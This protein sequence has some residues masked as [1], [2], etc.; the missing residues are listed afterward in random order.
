MRLHRFLASGET[1]E[2]HET[3][4]KQR[5]LDETIE[6]LKRSRLYITYSFINI[7]ITGPLLLLFSNECLLWYVVFTFL[8]PLLSLSHVSP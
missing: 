6:I 1:S 5:H 4:C 8:S 7:L 2:R 3:S